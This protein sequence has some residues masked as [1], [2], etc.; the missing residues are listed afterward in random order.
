MTAHEIEVGCWHLLVRWGRAKPVSLARGYY[1]NL[2]K[3]AFQVWRSMEPQQK[4]RI[5]DL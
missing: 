1:W 4:K 5:R 2:A 3:L